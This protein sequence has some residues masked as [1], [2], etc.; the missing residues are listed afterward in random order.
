MSATLNRALRL[1]QPPNN[2]SLI[3]ANNLVNMIENQIRVSN[4]AEDASKKITQESAEA[5]SWFNG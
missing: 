3:W 4:L 1:P 2:Y 5:V